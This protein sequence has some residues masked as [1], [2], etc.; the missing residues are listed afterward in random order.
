MK[1]EKVINIGAGAHIE[2]PVTIAD[3]IQNSFNTLQESSLEDETKQLLE[4]L[5]TAVTAVNKQVAPDKVDEA[6]AMVRDA[7]ALVDEA[8]SAKP[9][10]RWYEVSVEGLKE[11]ANNIGEIAD[12]VLDIVK[13]LLPLLLAA[14]A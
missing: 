5:L 10:R 14:A 11:A 9:R 1:Q 6:E 8:T 7:K 4:Q 2:A 13:K 3:T 12:P